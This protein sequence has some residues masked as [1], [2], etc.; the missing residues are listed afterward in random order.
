MGA[1]ETGKS[2][3]R[4]DVFLYTTEDIARIFKIGR[5][6]AYHLMGSPGF[7]S[8]RLNRKMYVTKEN[9]EKWIQ[10]NKGKSYIF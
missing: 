1:Q 4:D 10:G 5:T 2:S 9:L 6:T 3:N 7:P 8:F